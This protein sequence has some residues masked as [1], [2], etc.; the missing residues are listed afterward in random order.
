MK[1][2]I[3][4]IG[5]LIN[6][7]MFGQAQVR[8]VLFLGNSYTSVNNLPYLIAEV[9]K[10]AGDSLYYDSYLIGGYTLD[11]HYQDSNSLKK[12]M[13][14]GWD[15][16][17]L[18][19]QSQ[20]P[21]FPDY[22]GSGGRN[23][24][25]LIQK[26]NPCA[27]TMFYM[28]WG[29]KNGDA[30]NC[31]SWPPVCT[32]E[33][34][35]S[36]L[37]LS[38]MQMAAANHADVSPV[39]ALWKYIR[40]N[41]PGI[42][43]YQSDE[44]HPSFSGSYAAACSF[45]SAI[46]KKDPS[47]ISY[48]YVLPVTEA[49]S[50][51]VA[52]KQ[53]VFD[54]LQSWHFAFPLPSAKFYY[55]IG[56]GINEVNFINTSFD[57]ETY[58]W[59]FGDGNISNS[60]NPIHDFAA[61]GSYIITLMASSCDMGVIQASTYQTIIK[62]CPFNPVILPDSIIICPNSSDTLWTQTYNSYMWFNETGEMIPGETNQYLSPVNPGNYSV[63]ATQ[64]GCSE[65]SPQSIV[66]I[67]HS[68]QSFYVDIIG[69]VDP[70]NTFSNFCQGDS[71]KLIL[72]PN[73]P[74]YPNDNNIQW[75]KDGVA[76]PFLFN[77]TIVINTAGT[78]QVILKDSVYCPGTIIYT[79]PPIVLRVIECSPPPSPVDSTIRL[80]VY[81]N[82]SEGNFVIKIDPLM[83]GINYTVHDAIGKLIQK[84]KLE[85][86]LN[87]LDLTNKARGNYIL[88]FPGNKLRPVKL[89]RN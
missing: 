73:K 10:S 24:S 36:L 81:P 8:K 54:S 39:G 29:R 27:R 45:Y 57:T 59:D 7:C 1:Y 31:S 70:H 71:V 18:Q 15:Y 86:E 6:F 35:D 48:N 19:D 69:N 62:F 32:Y 58:M 43:L 78:Y 51:K 76:I 77:D 89:V 63:L 88:Q 49:N 22:S 87:D 25:T 52:A 12:I 33:G 42:E 68:L 47:F 75:F 55:T 65:M 60:K 80:I 17:V 34:M 40:Q 11:Q 14:G 38:Y 16:V 67:F 64:N 3:T 20:V 41:V 28:T 9:A 13:M 53:I 46:F 21:A 84:G 83:I 79:S 4:I 5:L 82:P 37:H 61:D 44:S 26:Y 74:P 85:N 72:V 66:S 23:L 30:S 2:I 56:T 50:I